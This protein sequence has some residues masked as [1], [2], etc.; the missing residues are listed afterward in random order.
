MEIGTIIVGVWALVASLFAV[1]FYKKSEG[2][3][4]LARGGGSSRSGADLE[5]KLEGVRKELHK[6]KEDLGRKD[7]QLEEAREQA[8]LKARREAKKDARE[9]TDDKKG[10]SDPRDVEIQ[11]LR[12]GMAALEAQLNQIKHKA[13][14]VEQTS[15]Q[16][17]E[18]SRAD[19]E[20][21]QRS[22]DG[23]RNRRKSLEDEN[24]A[25]KRTLE[26]LR[27]AMKKAEQRPDIP[28]STLDLKSLPPPAVQELS[29]YFRKGEEFERLHTVA[30]SQLQ[31]EKDRFLELQRRYFAVCRE[32]AVRAGLPAN[33]SE[34]ELTRQAEAEV[35]AA[36]ARPTLSLPHAGAPAVQTAAAGEGQKKKRRRRRK[37]K[38]AGESSLEA[39]GAESEGEDAEDDVDDSDSEPLGAP[40]QEGS[41][42]P[43][44]AAP[45]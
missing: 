30:Q 13:E 24:S 22:V 5:D 1:L 36:E 21:A 19:V 14:E 23:E 29:R 20:A 38:I 3:P 28:G 33:A 41:P 17:S 11:S 43:G 15:T 6:A 8:R 35:D 16:R 32:L 37:R 31:L 9:Q 42:E 12:K 4:A 34:G 40:S 44:A 45:A 10:G 18:Q 39:A 25:L 26:D 7:K 27:G 2:A